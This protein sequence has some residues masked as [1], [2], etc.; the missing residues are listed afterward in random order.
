MTEPVQCMYR[1]HFRGAWMLITTEP[2]PDGEVRLLHKHF[3]FL[4]QGRDLVVA[5]KRGELLHKLVSWGGPSD[6]P[7]GGER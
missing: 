6:L 5:R 3:A 4:V 2:V 1:K 7:A